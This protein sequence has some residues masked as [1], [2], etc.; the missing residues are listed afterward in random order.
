MWLCETDEL[1]TLAA[2]CDDFCLSNTKTIDAFD[3]AGPTA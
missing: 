3:R 1:P 2:R